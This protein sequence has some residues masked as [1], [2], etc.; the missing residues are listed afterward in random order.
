MYN[1]DLVDAVHNL[2]ASVKTKAHGAATCGAVACCCIV[3]QQSDD[4]LIGSE[5]PVVI[6]E[7]VPERRRLVLNCSA[8]IAA[9]K[10]A[11]QPGDLVSGVVKEVGGEVKRLHRDRPPA[12]QSTCMVWADRSVAWPRL[13]TMVLQ[14]FHVTTCANRRWMV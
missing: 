1:I 14:P 8:A 3:P 7:V 9:R 5:L 11:L 12:W 6:E 10:A 2:P 13:H 4:E